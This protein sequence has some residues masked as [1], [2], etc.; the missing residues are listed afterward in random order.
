MGK[1]PQV[2]EQKQTGV[3]LN[4][5]SEGK[6][7]FRKLNV[8]P[9]IGFRLTQVRQNPGSESVHGEGGEGHL[10]SARSDLWEHHTLPSPVSMEALPSLGFHPHS[11]DTQ[12]VLRFW[13]KWTS[14]FINPF[15]TTFLQNIWSSQT[16]SMCKNYTWRTY[17]VDAKLKH[18]SKHVW[19]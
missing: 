6:S 13:P 9:N 3:L 7:T 5:R 15:S 19:A 1:N 12:P 8:F 18:R 2:L 14:K 4:Y 10:G 16:C 11:D 17:T